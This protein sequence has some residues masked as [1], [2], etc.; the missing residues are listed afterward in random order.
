MNIRPLI[1]KLI[2][3]NPIFKNAK[4]KAYANTLL[5]RATKIMDENDQES[6]N[7]KE[8][9]QKIN[10]EDFQ[11]MKSVS[12]YERHYLDFE[13]SCSLFP[14]SKNR[15][16]ILLY[17]DN[18]EMTDIWDGLD[19]IHD[20]HY[21]DQSDKPDEISNRKWNKRM[22]DWNQVLG[23]D[24]YGTPSVYGVT[25]TFT[26]NDLPIYY[27]LREYFNSDD[28]Q[29]PT[30]E[31]RA[32]S[33]FKTKFINEA[34]ERIKLTTSD[35]KITTSIVYNAIDE[36]IEFIKTDEYKNKIQELEKKLIPIDYNSLK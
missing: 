8:E 24:G 35:D 20:Y 16:L 10:F 19:F 4:I 22:N 7:I 9:I 1:Q 3:V 26:D 23:G 29:Y 27:Y 15:T 11:Y 6:K 2:E 13:C 14:I 5:H 18:R 33:L 31:K 12:K 32:K 34:S 28:C 17:C 36:Y 30:N 21:Q 25:Y